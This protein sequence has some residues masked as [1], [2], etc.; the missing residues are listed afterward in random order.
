[1]NLGKEIGK[2]KALRERLETVDGMDDQ[3]LIDTLEGATDLKEAI[4]ELDQEIQER[5]AYALAL[6]MKID[7]LNERKGRHLKVVD[8]LRTI[9][10]HAMD[11]AGL[12]KIEGAE[13]TISVTK[14][15]PDLHIENEAA[16]PSQFFEPQPPKL[17]KTK[18]R[19]ALEEGPVEGARLGNG[20][21]NLSIRRK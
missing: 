1:M 10:L 20:G 19:K 8:R 7:E 4:L 15:K 5:E 13:A 3:C 2:W 12:P 17:D 14:R 11:N 9:I 21:I 16:L 6:A 18:L